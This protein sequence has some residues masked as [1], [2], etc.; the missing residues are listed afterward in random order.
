ME[1][2]LRD[3]S[4]KALR[5]MDDKTFTRTVQLAL[6]EVEASLL[7]VTISSKEKAKLRSYRAVLLNLPGPQSRHPARDDRVPST[8][9]ASSVRATQLE[10]DYERRVERPFLREMERNRRE[11]QTRE[12]SRG[13]DKLFES[14]M[15]NER[16]RRNR[17]MREAAG[18]GR[19]VNASTTRIESTP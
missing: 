10:S 11:R 6:E 9:H 7:D 1:I 13:E 18:S 4:M 3:T 5:E 16:N 17:K 14:L 19:M 8:S 12:A 2:F 15:E